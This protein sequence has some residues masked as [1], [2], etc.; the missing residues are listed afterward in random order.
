MSKY[1]KIRAAL[2]KCVDDMPSKISTVFSN[3]LQSTPQTPHQIVDILWTVNGSGTVN[4]GIGKTR[5]E[6]IL[7]IRPRFKAQTGSGE[8]IRYID[9]LSNYFQRGKSIQGDGVIVVIDRHKP[10]SP[11]YLDDGY[12][13]MAV[14]IGFYC[15]I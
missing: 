2:E 5:I 1:D 4:D 13:S 3:A 6:G 14:S 7:Q 12:F 15:Y 8:L 9:L 10:L 11:S